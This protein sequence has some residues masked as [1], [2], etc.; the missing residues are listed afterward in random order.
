MVPAES[1]L[2]V[3]VID[4]DKG[5][6]EKLKSEAVLAKAPPPLMADSEKA[7]IEILKDSNH[8]KKN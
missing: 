4:A 3:L 1:T 5:F 7:A 2:T 6:L 8:N